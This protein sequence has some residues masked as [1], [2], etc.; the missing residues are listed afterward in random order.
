MISIKG[1]SQQTIAATLL[2]MAVMAVVSCSQDDTLS[3]QTEAEPQPIGFN[4]VLDR[5]TASTRAVT[6]ITDATF[7]AFDV[8]AFKA[9][10][11]KAEDMTYVMGVSASKGYQI[12]RTSTYGVI[13]SVQQANSEG[14]SW[15]YSSDAC[16]QAAGD[17][18]AQRRHTKP[19]VLCPQPLYGE[20]RRDQPDGCS[21]EDLS[22]IYLYHQP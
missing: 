19:V 17:L 13:D 2:G 20:Y 15:T 7:N 9:D 18:L 22:L 1:I 10:D 12:S 5:Q 8:W 14:A 16:Q 11:S 6:S 4:V 3:R 21:H